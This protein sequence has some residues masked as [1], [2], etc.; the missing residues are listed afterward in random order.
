MW[1]PQRSAAALAWFH[2]ILNVYA[3]SAAK[4]RRS[5]NECG[6]K[7]LHSWTETMKD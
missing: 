1:F 5:G 3:K 4:N 7:R 2:K 6:E